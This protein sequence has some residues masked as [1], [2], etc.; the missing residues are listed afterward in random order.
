M[1]N[2]LKRKIRSFISGSVAGWN[3][4]FFNFIFQIILVPVFLYNW[5]KKIYSLWIIFLTIKGL[6]ALI[7]TAHRDLIFQ[8]ILSLGVKNKK[9]IIRITHSSFIV[10]TVNYFVVCLIILFFVKSNYL[11]NLL[12]ITDDMLSNLNLSLIL[13]LVPTFFIFSELYIGIISIY[14]FYYRYAWLSLNRIIS[15]NLIILISIIIGADYIQTILAY[16]LIE[17]LCNIIIFLNF[18]K[19]IQKKK[20]SVYKVRF[21][22]FLYQ[23]KIV[24]LFF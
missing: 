20:I 15:T 8:K 16:V 2:T 14:G 3:E 22:L 24:L 9:K 17:T 13:I 7:N 1:K 11:G 6:L 23:L 10:F 19:I 4:I 21:D 12:N 18:K 5:D